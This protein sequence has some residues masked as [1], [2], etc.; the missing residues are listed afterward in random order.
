MLTHNWFVGTKAEFSISRMKTKILAGLFVAAALAIAPDVAS[1]R[2][3]GGGGGA[4][5]GG[6][7]FH[8]GGG[9]H[10]GFTH[11]GFVTDRGRF[12]HDHDRFFSHSFAFGVPWPGYYNPDY[13]GSL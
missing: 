10:G 5:H 9:F 1:A 4:S 12:R 8:G 11:H 3:G 6:G 7:S 2:G 13:F